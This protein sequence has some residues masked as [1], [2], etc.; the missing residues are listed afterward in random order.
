M[1]SVTYTCPY[2]DAVVAIDRNPYMRDKSVT[3]EPQDGREYASTTGEYEEA[4]GIEFVCIGTQ[5][6][7]GDRTA[8]DTVGDPDGEDGGSGPDDGE[9]GCGRT[10]YLNYVKYERGRELHE[11]P[12]LEDT[13]RFDFNP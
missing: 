10:F 7:P 1:V 12:S 2:C 13:P 4:D 9:D 5:S 3:A 6:V 8:S 11:G